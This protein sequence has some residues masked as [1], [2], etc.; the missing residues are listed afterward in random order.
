[1][2]SK[3]WLIAGIA[4]VLISLFLKYRSHSLH[5]KMRKGGKTALAKIRA[6]PSSGQKIAYLRKINPFAFEELLLYALS[7]MGFK[8]YRNQ[9]YTGDGGVDG[10]FEYKGQIF[11]IQA[12]RYSGYVSKRHL[13]DFVSLTNKTNTLG[14]F[15]HTGKTGKNTYKELNN[16]PR[17]LIISGDNL[18][19]LLQGDAKFRH[20]LDSLTANINHLRGV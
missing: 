19:N 5:L 15:C 4:F 9:R 13:A 2:I 7:D 14:I 17:I 3:Y 10:R 12:K 20:A 8:I 11:L 16:N 18:I 6:F 1:M